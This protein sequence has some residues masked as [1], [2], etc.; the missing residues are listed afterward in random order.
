MDVLL[1]EGGY[2]DHLGEETVL[3]TIGP[4]LRAGWEGRY[5]IEAVIRGVH[6][7]G[8]D[9]D[10]LE[11]DEPTDRLSLNG[12]G[13]LDDC[14]LKVVVP[15]EIRDD[16]SA[17]LVLHMELRPGHPA[18]L[19]TARVLGR[20]DTCEHTDEEILEVVLGRLNVMLGG[21]KWRCCLTCGLSDYSPGGQSFMGMRCHRDAG[22]QY[23]ACRGK[24]E[25]WGIPVTEVVPEFHVC[26]T[27]EPRKPG[28]GYR[29]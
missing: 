10:S 14:V 4:S 23:R 11:A 24:R 21:A 7:S 25:Y 22:E 12:G 28:T 6:V 19:T 17:R 9:F 5:A 18:P 26:P 1:A 15:A 13:E 2:V 27:W 20:H 29:G 8:A 16:P 3:W